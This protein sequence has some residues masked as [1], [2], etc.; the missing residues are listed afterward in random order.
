MKIQHLARRMFR[1]RGLA[2]AP[3]EGENLLLNS[4]LD[5]GKQRSIWINETLRK[6]RVL[7]AD[8]GALPG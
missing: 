7:P 6:R 3:I 1:W 8:P 4:T 5:S 2:L